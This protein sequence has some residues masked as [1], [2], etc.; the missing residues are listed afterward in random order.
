MDF[1]PS[2]EKM[3]ERGQ[4]WFPADYDR[5]R[6]WTGYGKS[7]VVRPSLPP[8]ASSD[9]GF[10]RDVF[11]TEAAHLDRE[12]GN[13]VYADWLVARPDLG[14][15]V[16]ASKL[17]VA[18]TAYYDRLLAAPIGPSGATLKEV[19]G[20]EAARSLTGCFS[21]RTPGFAVLS[22]TGKAPIVTDTDER[23]AGLMGS[24]EN[25]L[26]MKR[27]VYGRARNGQ[28][29]GRDPLARGPDD[30]AAPDSPS[31]L[32]TPLTSHAA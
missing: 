4:I 13:A 9:L 31:Y 25:V 5:I 1:D 12:L 23:I 11:W 16:M 20:I 15:C 8:G 24:A 19:M 22:D 3:S 17:E 26:P 10:E 32:Y 27:A 28:R 29:R 7:A 14:V 6:W 18:A 2:P 21:S 30:T